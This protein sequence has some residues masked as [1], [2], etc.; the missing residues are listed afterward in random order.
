[1]SKDISSFMVL[2]LVLLAMAVLTNEN[3]LVALLAL[4][5]SLILL[6]LIAKRFGNRKVF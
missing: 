3:S 5:V 6:L 1:M 2:S 4:P